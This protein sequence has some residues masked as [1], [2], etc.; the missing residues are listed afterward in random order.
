MEKHVE[1]VKMAKLEAPSFKNEI[2]WQSQF[3]K[4]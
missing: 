2:L 4:K 3:F 1:N